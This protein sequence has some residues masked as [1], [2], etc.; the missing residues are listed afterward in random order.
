[1]RSIFPRFVF[2]Q[3]KCHEGLEA[4]K[5]YRREWNETRKDWT[6]HPLH[7]WSSHAADSLR[8]FA[9]GYQDATTASK[10]AAPARLSGVPDALQWMGAWI[11]MSLSFWQVGLW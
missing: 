8:C 9:Q 4:L 6:N 5:A 2:D 7:D 3:E 10:P 1:V 11:L